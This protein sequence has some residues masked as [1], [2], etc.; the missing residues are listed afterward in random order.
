MHRRTNTLFSLLLTFALTIGVV[1][2]GVG[3]TGTST[4]TVLPGDSI[5]YA[6]NRAP[7]G[8]IIC[9]TAGI[10]DECITISKSL[11]LRGSG[12]TS[13]FLYAADD[14]EARSVIKITSD[15]EIDVRIEHLTIKGT[16]RQYEGMNV[17][18]LEPLSRIVAEMRWDGIAADKAVNVTIADSTVTLC[19]HA[20]ILWTRGEKLMPFEGNLSMVNSIISQSKYGLYMLGGNASVI[21]SSFLENDDT[22][23]ISSD[24]E[25]DAV[26]SYFDRN[27]GPIDISTHAYGSFT[28]CS[29]SQNSGFGIFLMTTRGVSIANSRIENNGSV[30][31]FAVAGQSTIMNSRIS[32]NGDGILAGTESEISITDCTIA[33]NGVIGWGGNGIT[34]EDSAHV[35]L[36]G[37]DIVNN[38]G[39]GVALDERFDPFA[40]YVG[41]HG[42]RIIVPSEV[43]GN[44]EGAVSPAELN[45]L[46]TSEGGEL[47]RRASP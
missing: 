28:N 36:I 9:L 39:Y 21:G 10:W 24:G 37:N 8:A 44:G 14:T 33:E 20:I 40:G 47:D 35:T 31:V 12:A 30:G 1:V 27:E 42:N 46:M 26:D 13:T 4:I 29:I 32:A 23:R 3:T 25:I 11:T 15:Q 17:E 38:A 2:L 5:Q 45:F 18:E 34:I 22:V 41:G 7:S 16:R 19:N 43:D 6:I